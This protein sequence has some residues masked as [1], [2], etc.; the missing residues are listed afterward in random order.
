MTNNDF[1]T[2]VA[3][4]FTTHLMG[5]RNLSPNTTKSYRDTFCLLLSFVSEVKNFRIEKFDSLILMIT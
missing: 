2:C 5:T 3:E 1:A 4:Y